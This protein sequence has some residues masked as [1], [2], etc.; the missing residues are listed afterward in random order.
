MHNNIQNGFYKMVWFFA[1]GIGL[2]AISYVYTWYKKKKTMPS[3]CPIDSAHEG[4]SDG[5]TYYEIDED[6][7][8]SKHEPIV[9]LVGYTLTVKGKS[10]ST[11]LPQYIYGK[12]NQYCFI[13]C[14]D[15][16][17]KHIERT[18]LFVIPFNAKV[19]QDL[20]FIE[21]KQRVKKATIWNLIQNGKHLRNHLIDLKNAYNEGKEDGD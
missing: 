11:L 3:S 4:S 6:E 19:A 21:N 12:Q 15:E 5:Y 2:V 7:V 1:S 9:N 18:A 16:E 13:S 17:C 8:Y 10:K 20:E 14:S